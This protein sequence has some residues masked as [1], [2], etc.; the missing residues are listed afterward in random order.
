MA[1]FDSLTKRISSAGQE[2]AQQTKSFAEVTKLNGSIAEKEKKINALYTE[3]GRSYYQQHREDTVCDQQ[4]SVNEIREL[5]EQI[6]QCQEQIK[7]IKG[8]VK[9]PDCGSDVP[10]NA[11]YCNTCG[12]RMEEPEASPINKKKCP[13]CGALIAE[14]CLFCTACGTRLEQPEPSQEATEAEAEAEK[15]ADTEV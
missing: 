2:V 12:R 7:Q 11:R 10:S 5:Q 15:P 3:I 13:S 8:I 9:C 4:Q 14:N 1:F 6:R